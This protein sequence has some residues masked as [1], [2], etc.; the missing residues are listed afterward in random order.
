[1][2]I[3]DAQDGNVIF[4][5]G[6]REAQ[7]PLVIPVK[8]NIDWVERNKVAQVTESDDSLRQLAISELTGENSERN[9]LPRVIQS[10]SQAEREQT[11]YKDEISDYSDVS[12]DAYERVPVEE[13]GAAMLR[14]MGWKEDSNSKTVDTDI[15]EQARPSLLGLGAQQPPKDMV[16]NRNRLKRF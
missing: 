12:E 1:M 2:A 11:A 10:K 14:G 7:A 5:Q 4:G 8:R 16:S 15:H 3:V 6:E 9:Q 13:F